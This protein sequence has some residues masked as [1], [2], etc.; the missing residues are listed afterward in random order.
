MLRIFLF[1]LFILCSFT[2]FSEPLPNKPLTLSLREAILL[3][4]RENPSVQQAQ[5]NHVQQ[6]F[7][8][9]VAQWQFHPHFAITGLASYTSMVT[10]DDRHTSKSLNPQPF[11]HRYRPLAHR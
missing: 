9:E 2:A 5:L 3:T 6:K 10:N 8:L 1:G 11:Q 4:I 7:S